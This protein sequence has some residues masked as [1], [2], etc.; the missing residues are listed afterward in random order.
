[1][2]LTNLQNLNR[3]RLF[4]TFF[5]FVACL[6]KYFL[7]YFLL[8]SWLSFSGSS[9]WWH[10]F[11]SCWSPCVSSDVGGRE[12]LTVLVAPFMFICL[13]LG[14]C[15]VSG[16]IFISQKSPWE[17]WCYKDLVLAPWVLLEVVQ[18]CLLS[19]AEFFDSKSK[20][21]FKWVDTGVTLY[22]LALSPALFGA[23]LELHFPLPC[24][25]T[26]PGSCVGLHQSDGGN[27]AAR[28]AMC[29]VVI[30]AKLVCQPFPPALNLACKSAPSFVYGHLICMVV[31]PERGGVG[32]E[33]DWQVIGTKS[34]KIKFIWHSRSLAGAGRNLFEV[35][36]ALNGVI[37]WDV[38]QWAK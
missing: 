8:F 34:C 18:V 6:V 24:T 28:S 30:G 17:Q 12:F 16:S 13:A 26:A 5:S 36:E 23:S 20:V 27:L 33:A 4:S 10:T 21:T 35:S 22:L 32:G 37:S 3:N 7:R 15:S 14:H 2:K 38:P 1:M 19:G 11:C 25:D 29:N 9:T 31:N